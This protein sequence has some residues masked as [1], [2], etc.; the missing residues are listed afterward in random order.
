MSLSTLAVVVSY[1]DAAR[2]VACVESLK[3][4]A[5]VVVWDN[6]SHD[7]TIAVLAHNHSD[8]TLHASHENVLWTP[9]LNQAMAMFYD[10]EDYILFSNNDIVYRPNTL[11]HLKSTFLNH[12]NV[13]IVAPSGSALGGLQ[14]FASHWPRPEHIPDDQWRVS[15]PDVRAT[16]VV[17]A[18]MMVSAEAWNRIGPLDD[19]MP[20]GAD[21]HDYCLRAKE[22][23][24]QIWVTSSAY[25]NHVGHASA[26][27]AEP[28]WEEWGAKSWEAFNAKWDGYF[29]TEEE[30]SKCHWAG[31]YTPGWD[32]G[33]GRLSAEEREKV[34]EARAVKA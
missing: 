12:D 19:S 10:G 32:K 15:R 3:H 17:G 7:G 21:D 28:V 13:G 22:E 6:A 5:R 14:D 1:N 11:A 33:T 8:V 27:H 30:A 18:S 4:Q 16:Y 34:W 23:D 9:A 26:A 25:V 31:T 29:Y 24:Y 20:L 2:T